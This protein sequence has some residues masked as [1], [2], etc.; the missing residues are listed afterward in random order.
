MKLLLERP[1]R[2]PLTRPVSDP[3]SGV[4]FWRHGDAQ[5]CTHQTDVTPHWCDE[6]WWAFETHCP[7]HKETTCP[8]CPASENT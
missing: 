3:E 2:L 5:L 8:T 1:P 4:W 6:C 7:N